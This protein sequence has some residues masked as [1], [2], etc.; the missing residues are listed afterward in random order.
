MIDTLTFGNC[1]NAF[2]TVEDLMAFLIEAQP[3]ELRLV[4]DR[5]TET[6]SERALP[7]PLEAWQPEDIALVRSFVQSGGVTP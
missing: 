5:E 2:A 1:L 4:L 7:Q 3:E 6:Y